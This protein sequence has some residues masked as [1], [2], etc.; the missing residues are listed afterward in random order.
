[1][2]N[3]PG[4]QS[5]ATAQVFERTIRRLSEFYV[6]TTPVRTL[7]AADFGVPQRRARLFVIG[8]RKD[9]GVPAAIYPEGP[10]VEQAQR[11]TVWEALEDLPL[12][13]DRNLLNEDSAEYRKVTQELHSYVRTA[14]GLRNDPCD[15]SYPREW[16]RSRVSGCRRVKHRAEVERLY[17]ATAPGSIVPAHNLP[18]LLPDGL[19]PTLRAGTDSE[20]GSFNAPRP[21]HP[22]EPRCIT[23]REAARLHGYPDWFEFYPVKWHAHRQ[24]G[25]SVCPQIARALGTAI[26]CA[27]DAR[28]GRPAGVL[29]LR[30]EFPLASEAVEYHRRI[31]QMEEWPK[32]LNRLLDKAGVVGKGK[33]T[34]SSFTV[35]DVRQAYK[36]IGAR[37]QRTPPDRF[38]Q[39]IARSR[40]RRSIMACVLDQ[41]LSILTVMDGDAYGQFVKKGTLGTLEEREFIAVSSEEILLATR[42]PPLPTVH[43]TDTSL[44]W[45]LGTTEVFSA[46]FP[47]GEITVTRTVS[48]PSYLGAQL[49][50]SV[51]HC[52]PPRDP[53]SRMTSFKRTQRKYVQKAYR[54]RNWREYETGLR[55]RGSLTVWLGLTDGKLANW[56]SPRPTRRKPGRQRQYSNHAIETTVTLG[57]VF[58]L[59]SRQTEG[60]LRSLLTLLNLDNDVP[61]HSTISR[62]KARLGKVAS[63]E[64]RTVKPVHLRI[65]SSG[66]SVHVGQLRT[67]PKARDSRKLHLAVDEQTSD[68]V[69]C[70]LTSKRARD[71]SRVASLVGQIERPIASAKADAAYDTGDV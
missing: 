7:N 43:I 46:L 12:L 57:L 29:M 27:L 11:P 71:A 68:V 50:I 49:A 53:R 47:A 59:A 31:P 41:G 18:R 28:P 64:R 56:N 19:S 37:M 15:L 69:A 21:I 3:V 61:D 8:I 38:L 1:M 42:V 48:R 13:A 17:A 44:V 39:D 6:V 14:R 65:D 63:Y 58:G 60:F 23:V 10:C 67:P 40:N 34:R 35:D 2:E 45:Y 26:V 62:R 36:A 24:I 20:H 33:V 54:V 52:P 70:A 25:N 66:L 5:G 32:V 4:L 22:F 16:D 30:N 9:L 51:N 55:A